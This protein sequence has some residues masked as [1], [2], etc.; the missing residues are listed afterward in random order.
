MV[1]GFDV[2]DGVATR[3][4]TVPVPTGATAV[5]VVAD[6]TLNEDEAFAPK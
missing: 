2:P 6:A 3:T 4:S 1:E 5:T